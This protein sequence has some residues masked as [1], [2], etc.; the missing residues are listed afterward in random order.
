MA[1]LLTMTKLSFKGTTR[2]GHWI[3]SARQATN[4]RAGNGCEVADTPHDED[5]LH[6]M[7]LDFTPVLAT[8][9]RAACYVLA[10]ADT[11]FFLIYRRKQ[12]LRLIITTSE[13]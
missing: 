8:S 4:M 11:R 6:G 7:G 13:S 5:R 2:A 9:E 12:L 1:V 3:T 10:L